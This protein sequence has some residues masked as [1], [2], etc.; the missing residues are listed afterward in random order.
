[1][2]AA[3]RGGWRL[4]DKL[5]MLVACSIQSQQCVGG[6]SPPTSKLVVT[7]GLRPMVEIKL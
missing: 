4:I 1:M 7:R 6:D 2:L 3:A 5:G